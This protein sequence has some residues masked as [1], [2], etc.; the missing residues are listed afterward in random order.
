[1]TEPELTAG[2]WTD[3]ASLSFMRQAMGVLA[4]AR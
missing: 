3:D 2:T 4:A 1:M